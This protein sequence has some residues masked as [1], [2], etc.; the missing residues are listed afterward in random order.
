MLKIKKSLINCVLIFFVGLFFL[1]Q[2][3]FAEEKAG[4][5]K[6]LWQK[7]FSV[8]KNPVKEVTPPPKTTKKID[9]K[10]KTES[11][12]NIDKKTKRPSLEEM[13]E[14][15]LRERITHM[16]ETMP[17]ALDFIPA[18]KVTF[19]K[20]GNASRVQYDAQGAWRDLE[21]LDKET[22][23][24]IYSRLNS[25]RTRLQTE[26]IQRQLESVRA[27]QNISRLPQPLTPPNVPK[28]PKSPPVP[29]R[30]Y[31]PPQVPQV[32]NKVIIPPQVSQRR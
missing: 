29:P 3:S 30:V 27:A 19:D 4:F 25:E 13:S 18:L 23:I 2:T 1:T 6:T 5:V 14:R 20:E 24:K 7:T 17:E 12:P 15:E 10:Q 9:L 28:I 26:R 11:K 22:L 32:P 8:L 16:I 21:T 31:T